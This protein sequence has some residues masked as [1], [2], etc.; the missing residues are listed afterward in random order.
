MKLIALIGALISIT[1]AQAFAET[2]E[3]LPVWNWDGSSV[4]HTVVIKEYDSV[5]APSDLF[6]VSQVASLPGPWGKIGLSPDSK[7]FCFQSFNIKKNISKIFF[8]T[9]SSDKKPKALIEGRYNEFDPVFLNG[10]EI[11]FCS[12]RTGTPK[13]WKAGLKDAKPTQLTFKDSIDLNP[14]VSTATGRVVFNA[15]FPETGKTAICLLD[16][17]SSEYKYICDGLLPKFSPDGNEI[18]FLVETDS[19]TQ[20]WTTPLSAVKP[21]MLAAVMGEIKSLS[22]GT[23]DKLFFTSALPGGNFNVFE[24]GVKSKKIIQLTSNLSAQTEVVYSPAEN[25]LYF[26]SNRGGAWGVWRLDLNDA[27]G[28]PAPETVYFLAGDGKAQLSWTPA[29]NDK[30]DGYNV[31]FK[32]SGGRNWWKANDEA[33]QS[34]S[35]TVED[36]KN[37]LKYDFCVTAVDGER[38]LESAYSQAV[39]TSPFATAPPAVVKAPEVVKKAAK[40]IKPRKKTKRAKTAARPA[41]PYMPAPKQAVPAAAVPSAAPAV[42]APSAPAGLPAKAGSPAP[43]GD[44]WGDSKS[45]SW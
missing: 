24:I 6:S 34:L 25:C 41:A 11:V 33:V 14:A 38:G 7:K 31:Y 37:Y 23:K 17:G 19:A 10:S 3:Y 36:L 35:Y 42:T 2:F 15:I 21:V 32:P 9:F 5:P 16:A 28:L 22:W 1:V 12:D 4:K 43:A 44:D 8:S 30:G 26:T 45:S 27:F 39:S 13:L 40:N 18:A 20:I 29:D